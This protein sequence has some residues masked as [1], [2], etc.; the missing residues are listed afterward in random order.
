MSSPHEVLYAAISE[1][2]QDKVIE[3]KVASDMGIISHEDEAAFLR[4]LSGLIHE[5]CLKF[6][7]VDMAF[8]VDKFL[9]SCGLLSFELGVTTD[10]FLYLPDNNKVH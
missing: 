10:S 5:I 6:K 2:I 1:V 9:N 4:G 3:T 7:A 8:D